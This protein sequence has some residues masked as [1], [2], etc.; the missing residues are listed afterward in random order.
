MAKFTLNGYNSYSGCDIVVTARLNVI[1]G[2]K[3]ELKEKIYSLG[4]LQ[5]LSI[6]THQD[7]KPVRVIGSAN[8]LDYTMGQRTIAGSL[9]FAVFDQHFATEMFNDLTNSTGKTFLLPDE[10]PALDLTITF[11]NEYGRE[12]RMAIYGVRIINEGQVMS[13]NDLYTE[14][15]YQFVANALEPLRKGIEAGASSSRNKTLTIASSIDSSDNSSYVNGEEIYNRIVIDNINE[16]T[17]VNL[18]ASVEQPTYVN[19]KGIVRLY[20]SPSQ[21]VGTITIL[22]KKSYKVVNEIQIT[23]NIKQYSL[24]LDASNYEAWYH[25]NEQILSNTV[26]FVINSI[27]SFEYSYN[28][29][30]IIETVTHNSIAAMSNNPSHNIGVCVDNITS[31][32]IEC[33]ISSRQFKFENLNPISKYVIYT[34]NDSNI[35]RPIEVTTLEKKDQLLDTFKDY[36]NTNKNLL[37]KEISEYQELLDKLDNDFLYALTKEK[38]IEAKELIYMAIKYKNELTAIMNNSNIKDMP[39]KRIDNIFGNT[40]DFNSGVSKANIFINKN[41]KDYFES[42]ERY[43]T[44]I[45]YI[46]KANS[47]YNVISINDNFIK[48]PKYTFYAYSD[49]DKA[50]IEKQFGNVNVLNGLDIKPRINNKLSNISLQCLTAL[51][52]KTKDISLLKAPAGFINESLDLIVNIDYKDILGKKN[53]SYYLCISKLEECLDSTPFRKIEIDTNYEITVIDKL[54]TAINHDD[55]FAIWIEDENFNV[56][57]DLGFVSSLEDVNDLNNYIIENNIATIIKKIETNLNKPGS[58][59]DIVSAINND[60]ANIKDIYKHLAI[61][62]INTKNDNKSEYIYELFKNKFSEM[63]VV[64]EK[65]KEAVYDKSS[66]TIEFKNMQDVELVQ[67]AIKKDDYNVEVLDNNKAVINNNYDINIFYLISSNPIIKSGFVMIDN[68]KAL[69]HLINLEVI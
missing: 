11:A 61:S 4:S 35:S 15:T 16:S 50:H 28:D 8:A 20:L 63:Y 55:I 36:V 54:S 29:T 59:S 39:V 64:K 49:N 53:S 52:H 25:N 45:T 51:E 9:V 33:E 6:S 42:S 7:K 58:L 5:T 62:I 57:S 27:V 44:E 19:Q 47:L 56:I 1:T 26:S 67:I 69:S 2:A 10:L 38:S 40:F 14:N 12:S 30:P 18:V 34:K 22:D 37:S 65:Y 68:K 21:S 24:E 43:P 23:N 60:N 48:S 32:A 31:K 41:K 3:K 17:R 13:I 46:G 66:N